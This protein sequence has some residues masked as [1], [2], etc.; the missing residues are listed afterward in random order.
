MQK[1][2]KLI[3]K[4]RK[5]ATVIIYGYIIFISCFVFPI[6]PTNIQS[7][8]DL[9]VW[10]VRLQ[11]MAVY[12]YVAHALYGLY[13]ERSLF[14]FC[15][16]FIFNSIGLLCRVLLEWGESSMVRDLIPFNVGIHLL[17]IPIFI[18]I[19]YTKVPILNYKKLAK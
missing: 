9:L 13:K 8:P 17:L 3:H 15:S 10:L 1:L 14:V 5:S 12:F 11:V 18:T 7:Y 16:T 4:R 19:V 2:Y 6:L